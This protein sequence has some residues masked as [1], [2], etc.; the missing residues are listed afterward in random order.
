VSETTGSDRRRFDGAVAL[1]TG[2]SRGIGLAIARRL[3]DEGAQVCIT[4]RK[5]EPLAEAVEGLGGAAHAMGVAGKADDVEHQ[6]DTVERIMA[7]YGR[8]DHVV[9]NSGINPAYGRLIDVELG[10]AA[11][12]FQV[13]VLA[14]LGWTQH[15]YRAWMEEH[16]GSVVNVASAAGLRPAPGMG[17]Y[18]ASKRALMHVTEELGLE[19]A[20]GVRVNS[21]APAVVKTDFAKLLYEG[22]ESDVV[23]GY[24]MG[25]LGVPADIASAVAF[26]LCDESSWVT[27]QHI[28]L[29]GGMT[30]TGG[31]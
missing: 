13:N 8:L 7:T 29:D 23:E 15:A 3:V 21:V 22:K 11:K 1:V 18:G 12:I 17:A 9:N 27:G 30:L 19:L 25:R 24:P 10:A 31:V 16:G 28:V 4:A 2:A 6:R 20:P 14:A 26:L 5:P